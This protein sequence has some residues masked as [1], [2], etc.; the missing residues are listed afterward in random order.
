[1]LLAR[2]L[3]VLNDGELVDREV[4]V[5]VRVVPAHQDNISGRLLALGVPVRHLEGSRECEVESP[6]IGQEVGRLGASDL[7]E[8]VVQHLLGE[9]GVELLEGGCEAGG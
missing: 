4:L 2:R 6:V 5:G 1:M 7:A 9:T 3:L 8:G